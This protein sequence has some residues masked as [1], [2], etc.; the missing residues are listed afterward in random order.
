M[1]VGQFCCRRYTA[2]LVKKGEKMVVM[3]FKDVLSM[4]KKAYGIRRSGKFARVCF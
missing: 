1:T 3:R 2:T 4:Y